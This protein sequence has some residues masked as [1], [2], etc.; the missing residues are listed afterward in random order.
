M[1]KGVNRQMIEIMDTGNPY[2]ERALLVVQ[3]G[4]DT[5]TDILRR[6]ARD[7]LL[8]ADGC[9]HLKRS[10]RRFLLSYILLSLCS[11]VAGAVIAVALQILL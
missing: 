4:I 5:D 8:T 11:A 9:S 7:L 3:P 10:R 6:E 2:F 1:I